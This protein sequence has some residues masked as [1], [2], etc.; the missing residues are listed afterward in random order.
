MDWIQGHDQFIGQLME[1]K[2]MK[3]YKVISSQIVYH[4][5]IIEANSEEEADQLAYEGDHKWDFYD[6]GNWDIEEVEDITEEI[7]N[8]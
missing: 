2:K 5:T 7:T 3:K 6:C 8:A 1:G 4:S